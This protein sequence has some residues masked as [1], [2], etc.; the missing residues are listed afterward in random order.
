MLS[1]LLGVTTFF[2]K[3]SRS[4]GSKSKIQRRLCDKSYN[5]N[6]NA[7]VQVRFSNPFFM[8]AFVQ[9]FNALDQTTKTND[10]VDALAAYFGQ[11]DDPD[12][13]WTIALLSHRRPKRTVT[14]SA[15]RE[16]A[17]AHAGIPL[18]LFEESYHVVGDLAETIAAVLPKPLE[19]GDQSLSYWIQYI[20]ALAQVDE[21]EKQKRIVAAWTQQ[22]PTERFLFN[23]LIT[24]GFRVGVS[25]KLMVRA[26]AQFSGLEENVLAHRLMGNWTPDSIGFQ[27]LVVAGQIAEDHSKPYPFYLAYALED[28]PESLGEP[29]EWY[30]EHKWDGIRGQLIVRGGEVFV[31]SRGEEL[32]TDKFPEYL[33]LAQLLPHGTVIDGE[34]LPFKDGAPLSFQV[35]QTRI[36]RKNVTKNIL[37]QAPVV[38]RAYDLLEWGGEDWRNYP[39][40]ERRAQ[41]EMVVKEF[42]GGI[43]QLSELVEFDNWATLYAERQKARDLQSEGLMLKR[44]SATYRS[45]RKRGDWWKWKVDPLTVDAVMIYA[46]QGHGRRANLYTDFTFAVFD[47][48]QLVPFTKAYSG[49][50]DVEFNA[51]NVWIRNN[52]LERFGPVR[53]V[54]AELVFELA[55]EGIQLSPR[56]KS[57]VALRFPRIVRWRKDKP[58]SEINTLDDLKKLL[59]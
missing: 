25:Q 18:W 19:A 26:L 4:F 2:H 39:L 24:G 55:F 54:K 8:Q 28:T 27:D 48:D 17:A 32:V 14:T 9:L 59:S 45:G 12:K 40:H 21:V 50:T 20:Q 46:Q 44:K 53:S 1:L 49:L 42:G 29:D 23:K 36:G 35:L 57:G 16:W 11:V 7:I 41:L 5:Q 10:K 43:L 31:W 47:G 52:T 15:L 22:T 58:L 37:Q 33:P 30:A 34:I 3:I 38:L 13:L 51:I 6:G 56:H